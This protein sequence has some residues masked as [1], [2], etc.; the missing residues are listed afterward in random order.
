[1]DALLET[2]G[3]VWR[4]I[5]HSS[6]KAA[7]LVVVILA[8]QLILRGKLAPKWRYALWMLV[9]VQLVLPWAPESR[10]SLYNLTPFGSREAVVAIPSGLPDSPG[11]FANPAQA[12]SQFE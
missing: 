10:L 12:E 8:I 11:G 7:V 9:A 1:M 4:W 6:A 3:E 5:A 2:L